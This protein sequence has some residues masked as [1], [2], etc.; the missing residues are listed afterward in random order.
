MSYTSLEQYVTDIENYVQSGELSAE[1]E[2]YSAVRFRGQKHNR[3]YLEQGITYLEFRCFDLNPF[4]HLG[5]SQRDLRYCPSLLLG[6]LW[7]DDV[8]NVDAVL[9]AAHDLNQKIACSHPLTALPD[10]ADSSAL[11]QAMEEL[12]Q[13]F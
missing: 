12:I 6:L 13:H 7:L 2:F 4:D 11:L 8:E 1:K 9:K 3:A 5:I 10:E